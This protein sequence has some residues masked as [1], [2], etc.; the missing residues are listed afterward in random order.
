MNDALIEA[1]KCAT[2]AVWQCAVA[3]EWRRQAGGER[4][5]DPFEQF[6]EGHA[7]RVALAGELIAL[8]DRFFSQYWN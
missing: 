6:Q 3:A 4:C 2:F 8:A 1:I 7:D 5:V